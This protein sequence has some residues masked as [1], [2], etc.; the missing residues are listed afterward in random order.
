MVS[1]PQRVPGDRRERSEDRRS[2]APSR[3]GTGGSRRAQYHRGMPT[4]TSVDRPALDL[5]DLLPVTV[6]TELA[7]RVDDLRVDRDAIAAL[8]TVADGVATRRW[9]FFLR[10]CWQTF[11]A[12]HQ[13]FP[14]ANP[15]R[16]DRKDAVGIGSSPTEMLALA[17]QLYLL[18]DAGVEGVVLEAGCFKG[19]SSCCL[20]HACAALGR[21]L[22]VADSFAGLPPVAGEAGDGVYYQAGDFAGS[23]AEVEAN[24][25]TFG[26]PRSVELLEGFFDASLVG[27]SRPIA[28]LWMDV[29]L[30]S[31]ARDVLDACLDFVDPRGWVFS[32]DFEAHEMAGQIVRP[33]W[34]AAAIHERLVA[35]DPA[36]HAH[37]VAG[38]TAAFGWSGSVGPAAPSQLARLAEGLMPGPSVAAPQP[39]AVAGPRGWR[40][41]IR[42]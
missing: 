32:H 11:S 10:H 3:G 9:L 2:G 28:L 37:F 42:W 20:S 4:S 41:W 21:R 8:E 1:S 5:T 25:W 33:D 24:L 38:N 7:G 31:S 39:A 29:D 16:E 23:R 30:P 12:I 19:F 13:H 36:Y 35:R 22:V 40:Q 27:W 17:H 34:L 18:D 6:A 26:R 15:G 14:A